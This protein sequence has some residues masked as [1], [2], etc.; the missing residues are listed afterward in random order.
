MRIR[1]EMTVNLEPY[2][3]DAYEAYVGV[4]TQSTLASYILA[5]GINAIDDLVMRRRAEQ[6]REAF[7]A[8]CTG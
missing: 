8:A 3:V 4:A 7:S 1:I 5:N 2:Q 6:P